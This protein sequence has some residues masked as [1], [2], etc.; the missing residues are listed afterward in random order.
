MFR[1]TGALLTTAV[2][3][4]FAVLLLTGDYLREGPVLLTLSATHGIHRGDLGIVAAW[5]LGEVGVLVA[6]FAG[7]RDRRRAP[8]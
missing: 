2:L 4:G 7:R 3:S 5:V 1:W 6:A 8:A